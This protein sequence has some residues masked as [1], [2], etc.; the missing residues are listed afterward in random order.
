MNG[1]SR[2]DWFNKIG[3]PGKVY[4]E[5]YT[6]KNKT[7]FFSYQKKILFFTKKKKKLENFLKTVKNVKTFLI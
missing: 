5:N 2:E 7:I 6:G 4:I 1:S 3:R